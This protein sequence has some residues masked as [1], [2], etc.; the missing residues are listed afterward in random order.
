MVAGFDYYLNT[1]DT[2]LTDHHMILIPR[3]QGFT[4]AAHIDDRRYPA[5]HYANSA[6][7][8]TVLPCYAKSLKTALNNHV[9]SHRTLLRSG[10]ATTYSMVWS[11][12]DLQLM[13][14]SQV[15]GCAIHSDDTT[16]GN[17]LDNKILPVFNFIDPQ[18]YATGYF[19][20]RNFTSG[21]MFIDNKGVLDSAA[22]TAT[23]SVRPIIVFG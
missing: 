3:S 22:V 17:G 20:L 2:K 1:G 16:R 6:L 12:T 7:H 10:S 14:E 5:A 19:W 8:Q 15:F 18:A 4:T 9:L 13:T 21:P 11:S 23:S